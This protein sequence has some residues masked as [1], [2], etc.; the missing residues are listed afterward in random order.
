MRYIAQVILRKQKCSA[1]NALED[2]GI[3]WRPGNLEENI[4]FLLRPLR[5]DR[6]ILEGGSWTG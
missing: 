2:C 1:G 5:G 6:R 3:V 4:G